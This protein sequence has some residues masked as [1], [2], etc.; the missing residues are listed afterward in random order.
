[1]HT[2]SGKHC[3]S[4][5]KADLSGSHFDDVNMSGWTLHN[6]NMSGMRVDNANVAGLHLSNANLAGAQIRDCRLEGM[7]IIGV[8]VTEMVAAYERAK[9]K[10][11]SVA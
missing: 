9:T 11:A 10:D 1:M 4:V 5:T 3:L 7:M 6:V 8:L 2:L